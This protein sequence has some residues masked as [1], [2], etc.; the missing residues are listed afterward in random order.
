MHV[1]DEP[2][3]SSDLHKMTLVR[4]ELTESFL[5]IP[6]SVRLV[7]QAVASYARA[8]GITGRQLEAVR[9]ATSEAATNSVVHA[10][11]DGP[12]YVHVAAWVVDDELWILVAD[13]GVGCNIPTASPGLGLGLA[14][15]TDSCDEFTL[16][17][18]AG[19]GTE[20]RLC[21]RL[22]G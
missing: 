2:G 18:R 21:F 15:I 16:V 7:R 3:P 1:I 8:A 17:E 4:E 20:A 14:V 19:G 10:Y 22:T 11:R 5:A 13:D 6:S 12:G 9:L